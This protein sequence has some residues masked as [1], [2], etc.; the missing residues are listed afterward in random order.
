LHS[1]LASISRILIA[2]QE[3]MVLTPTPTPITEF[4]LLC[5]F[6]W[7]MLICDTPGYSQYFPESLWEWKHMLGPCTK[8][9]DKNLPSGLRQD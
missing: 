7:I 1:M 4:L 9:G 5:V 6:W 8:G 3:D 2:Q